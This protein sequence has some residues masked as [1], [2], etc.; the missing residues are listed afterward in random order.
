MENS[1]NVITCESVYFNEL[2][3]KIKTM[4]NEID[5]MK[6]SNLSCVDKWMNGEAV[7]KK[8]GVSKR[9]LQT[10]RD[11][12]ILKY[13]AVGSKFY[14]SIRDIEELMAKNYVSAGR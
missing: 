12:G 14:Y 8:L 5:L 9:T 1:T 2:I 11:T 3:S 7:M 10:Y 6:E 4:E 13:S